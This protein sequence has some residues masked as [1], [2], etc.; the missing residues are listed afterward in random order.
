MTLDSTASAEAL[1]G[2][3]VMEGLREVASELILKPNGSFEF[4]LVYGDADYWGGGSWRH[5]A[6]GISLESGPKL[7]KPF[8]LQR[9]GK[10]SGKG[11]KI[12][13]LAENR[14]G[15]ADIDVIV[16]CQQGAMRSRTN[17]DG[18]AYFD[19][20]SGWKSVGFEIRVYNHESGFT[21]LDTEASDFEF[22]VNGRAIME[23]RFEGDVLEVKEGYLELR[24]FDPDKPHKFRKQ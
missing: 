3:Y 12:S 14:N 17:L 21:A 7:G 5:V 1:L 20:E 9:K 24:K 13:V 16:E 2:R 22:A 10:H 6:G 15:V 11:L 8:V 19:L 18:E 23:M 4:A